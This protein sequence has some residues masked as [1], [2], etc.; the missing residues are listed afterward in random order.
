[1]LDTAKNLPNPQPANSANSDT[2]ANPSQ[3]PASLLKLAATAPLH[4]LST[5]PLA[6]KKTLDPINKLTTKPKLSTAKP[7]SLTIT[8][9][10]KRNNNNN[11]KSCCPS[12]NNKNTDKIYLQSNNKQEEANTSKLL[13]NKDYARKYIIS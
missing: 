2:I 12:Y 5:K 6:S 8:P 13:N 10:P 4:A 11:N 9:K 1:M 3:T 7:S